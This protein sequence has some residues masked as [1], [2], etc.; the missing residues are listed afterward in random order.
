[1]FSLSQRGGR[2]IG[3]IYIYD[4]LFLIPLQYVLKS[5]KKQGLVWSLVI[6]YGTDKLINEKSRFLRERFS[7]PSP[8]TSAPLPFLRFLSL[9]S[10]P[11]IHSIL[12]LLLCISYVLIGYII[13][14]FTFPKVWRSLLGLDQGLFGMTRGISSPIVSVFLLFIFSINEIPQHYNVYQTIVCLALIIHALLVKI[15]LSILLIHTYL[16]FS[17][18][19]SVIHILW[20]HVKRITNCINPYQ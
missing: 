17:I 6:N 12:S 16:S 10:H 7:A 11:L 8:L 18:Y 1:M 9:F 3:Y 15:F 4:C 14:L 2:R 19:S 13:S 5:L 20:I